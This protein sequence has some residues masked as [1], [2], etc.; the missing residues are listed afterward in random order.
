MGDPSP[1]RGLYEAKV[2]LPEFHSEPV[3]PGHQMRPLMIRR[4]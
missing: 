4:T 3:L 2:A 1:V